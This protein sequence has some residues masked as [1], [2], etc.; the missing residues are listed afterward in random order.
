MHQDDVVIL[1]CIFCTIDAVDV[2]GLVV[3]RVVY[4][5]VLQRKVEG[6]TVVHQHFIV[7]TGS[8]HHFFDTK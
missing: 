4:E 7:I 8:N 5:G 2:V 1:Q 6:V 3:E